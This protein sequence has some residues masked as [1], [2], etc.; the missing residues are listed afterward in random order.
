MS[1]VSLPQQFAPPW[2]TLERRHKIRLFAGSAL[3]FVLI[4]G[5]FF[6]GL[7]YYLLD[8]HA[9]MASPRHAEL[10]PS[11]TLGIRLGILGV[12]LFCCLYLYPLRKK[13]GWLQRIG[14][15][16]HWLDF[17]VLLGVTAPL[18]I[19]LHSSFKVRG[20]AGVAYWLMIA[21]MLSGFVGRYIYAQIPRSLNASSLSLKEMQDLCASTV[22][23]IE[24]LKIL[25][26][27]ELAELMRSPISQ[28]IE[29]MSFVRAV[30]LMVWIDVRRPFK[31]ATLRKRLMERSVSHAE[32]E[33]AVGLVRTESWLLT[34]MAFLSRTNQVFQLWHVVHRP[35]SYSFAVLAIV[36]VAVGILI[37]YF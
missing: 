7:S 21:V 9:R 18:V 24:R 26:R 16:K 29:N 33:R 25:P 12:F 13:W 28:E 31:V 3:L 30:V 14:K 1:T 37:G 11:G 22:G 5:T 32:V 23:E 35:F 2:L 27:E 20:L 4:V 34:K 8:A 17:H 19:T 10:K 36:H 6:Y 15:T